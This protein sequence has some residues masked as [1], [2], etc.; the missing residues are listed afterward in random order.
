MPDTLLST[1]FYIPRTHGDLVPRPRLIERLDAGLQGKLTLVSAPAGYGKTTLVSDWIARSKVPAAWL[2]LDPSDNDLARFL[3]YLIAALQAATPQIDPAVGAEIQPILESGADLAIERLL[4][5]LIN[6]VVASDASLVLVLEDYHVI[7]EFSIHQAL[8]FLF[9]HLPPAAGPHGGVHIVLLSRTD[10]PMPLGRLRVQRELTE[11]REA[12]LRFT[13][14]ET[15]LFL[16]EQMALAL[17]GQDVADLEARTEGWI[18]GLQLVALAL[19]D[20]PDRT[21]RIAALTGSHRYLI[22]YLG[23]EVMARQTE[24]VRTFLLRTSVLEQFRASLCDALLDQGRTTNDE[25]LAASSSVVRRPSSRSA[26]ILERLKRANLFLVPLDDEGQWYRYHRLFGDFLQRRLRST[27]SAR[28]PELYLRASRWYERQGMVDQ[29]IEHALA[30]EDVTRA[31]RLLDEHAE[32]YVFGAQISKLIRLAN[33]L[34]EGERCRF[35]RLCIYHAWALQFEYQLEAAE[36]AL[37]CV[38]AHLDAMVATEASPADASPSSAFSTSQI[39]HHVR[40]IRVYLAV[41]RGQ[42]DRAVERARTA[43]KALSED[44]VDE[45]PVVRGAVTLGLGIG[46]FQLGQAEAAY[47]VLQSALPLNQRDGNRYAALS[48]IYYLM[49][50][51]RLHGALGRALA[52]GREGLLWIE[53]WSEAEGQRAPLARVSAHIR[54]T[55]ARV[56]YERDELDEAA[57][58]I[59]PSTEY[60]ELVGSRFQV[61]GYA[62]LCDLLRALG[63]IE[64]AREYLDKL[65]RTVLTNGFSLPDTPVEA[66]IARR[67]LLLSRADARLGDLLAGAVRWAETVGLEW[68]DPLTHNREYELLTLAQVRVAQGRAAEV[69]SLL[70]RLVAAARGAPGGTAARTGQLIAV[71]ALQ[72]MAHQACGQ[73]DAAQ[74]ALS[75]ALALGEPEGYVRTFIDH[76]VPMA[77]LLYEA[78]T[79]DIAGRDTAAQYARRLL[80]AFPAAEPERSVQAHPQSSTHKLVEPLVEPLSERELEVLE[81]IAEGLTNP[82][83]ASRLFLSL[84]TVKA[85]AHHIYGK[86]DVHNRTQAV[87]R[88]RALGLLASV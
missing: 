66:M 30:G 38:E 11:I 33:R 50:I 4:T 35:P 42:P 15:G 49:R 81:L 58:H 43:L 36:S 10:P 70:E 76:G 48:C 86:L 5:A 39:A 65:E 31:A 13:V 63:E 72:A 44:A 82:E 68:D 75:R 26:E 83:I 12:D 6:D 67:R 85:H 53:Q 20:R 87:S 52:H 9:D 8:D 69:L 16:N 14:E 78:A 60:Y 79:R 51:D 59:R 56:H 73:I 45:P 71:L 1:K 2:S 74:N 22:D 55:M 23:Q 61:Q 57:R 37:A 7:H 41:Q 54:Q 3:G 24:E 77:R 47:R 64:G 40:A 18:A 17:S 34:P 80:S 25:P 29:A 19:Q 62:L 88:A 46:H 32:A 28:V 84:N 21:D 27:Q